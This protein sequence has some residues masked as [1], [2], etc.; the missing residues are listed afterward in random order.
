MQACV[1]NDQRASSYYKKTQADEEK[2]T[3]WKFS[4]AQMTYNRTTGEWAS[5]DRAALRGLFE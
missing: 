2:E 1:A 4:A 3:E 5:T